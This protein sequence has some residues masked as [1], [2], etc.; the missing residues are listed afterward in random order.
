MPERTVKIPNPDHPIIITPNPGRVLVKLAGQVI[1]NTIRALTLQEANYSAVQYIPR[2][3]VRMD[4]LACSSSH[5]YCP[6]KGEAS[7]FSIPAG[8]ARSVDAIWTYEEPYSAVA[9]IKGYLAFYPNR[10][11]SIEEQAA[12]ESETTQ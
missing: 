3:D 4:L 11:D 9:A 1:A 12:A 6:Y 7:Y 5:T 8:G 2:D 10:V